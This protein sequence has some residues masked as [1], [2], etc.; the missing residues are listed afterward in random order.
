[1]RPL[2]SPACDQRTLH[3]LGASV[4]IAVT[5]LLGG[6]GEN[7]GGVLGRFL[8]KPNAI[9]VGRAPDATYDRLFPH[10]VEL[11]ALS[12]WSLREGGRGNPF[13]HAVM[14]IKGACKDENAPFP[15]LRRCR[16]TAT[17]FDDPE[18]GVGVSVGRWFRN[19]NWVAVPGYALFYTGGLKPGEHLTRA[20]FDA[21]VREAIH[22][23]VFKGVELHSG[24]GIN[25]DGSLEDF[26]SNRSIGTD[27]ALQFSRNAFCAR[28]PVSEPVLD[29]VIAFLNDKN[30]EYATGE[31]DYNWNLFADNCVHTVRNALAAANIWSPISVL[32]IKIRHL[33]NPAVPANEFVN[34]A[35]LGAEGPIQ[36]DRQVQEDSSAR[37]A[38]YDFKWLPTR[39]GALVKTLLVHQPN[40]IYNTDFRLFAVQSPFRMGKAAEVVR[41]LSDSRYVDLRANLLHFREEYDNILAA[42]DDRLDRLAS[43]RGTPFRRI[44]RLHHEYIQAQRLE[45]EALLNQ[46]AALENGP[47][48]PKRSSSGEERSRP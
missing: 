21:T 8:L 27:F 25:G 6:C 10:Y 22:K 14:Y 38:L 1:M 39:H 35:L 47:E 33:L 36:D 26:V 43:V 45:V 28:L 17:A 7:G 15:Q 42:H 19:V 2:R 18:H 44:G 5:V 34:L 20:R 12:Q 3:K 48:E 37:D 4:L 9:I 11:C 29:E 40:D 16:G 30:Y 13:G 32:E 31:A 23:D 24:W 41:L 46:L